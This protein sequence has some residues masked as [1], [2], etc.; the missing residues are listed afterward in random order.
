[1]PA[2]TLKFNRKGPRRC[3]GANFI[4]DTNYWIGE[5]LLELQGIVILRRELPGDILVPQSPFPRGSATLAEHR[6][7]TKIPTPEELIL[8]TCL[9][10][11]LRVRVKLARGE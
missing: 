5:Y 2:A 4:S 9:E 7:T 3:A 6:T 1:M 11:T 8:L 10:T